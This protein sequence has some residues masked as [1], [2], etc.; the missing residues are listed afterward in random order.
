MIVSRPYGFTPS[1]APLS[2]HRTARTGKKVTER[3]HPLLSSLPPAVPGVGSRPESGAHG[4]LRA[5][6]APHGEGLEGVG[7]SH[8]TPQKVYLGATLLAMRLCWP[9]ILPTCLSARLAAALHSCC[10]RAQNLGQ[11]G[12]GRQGELPGLCLLIS[13][14]SRLL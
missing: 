7:S 4:L 2:N 9:W 5:S 12:A 13:P 1:W 11:A 14:L 8:G 6:Q 10:A 3:V